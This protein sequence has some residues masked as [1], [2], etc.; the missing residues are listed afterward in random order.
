MS[1]EKIDTL[2]DGCGDSIP[3]D[4]SNAIEF[5]E[6]EGATA[7]NECFIDM[8]GD[9]PEEKEAN[10]GSADHPKLNWDA[11]HRF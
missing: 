6:H 5:G 3:L 9:P 7:C 8:E 4:E 10:D 1:D 2:C 11:S